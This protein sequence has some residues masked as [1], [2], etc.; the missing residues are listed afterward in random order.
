[1][2]AGGAPEMGLRIRRR[3]QKQKLVFR[4][5]SAVILLYHHEHRTWC[6]LPNELLF[7]HLF[8]ST[9][10]TSLVDRVGNF[11]AIAAKVV[12]REHVALG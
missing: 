12:A 5:V 7:A 1:M 10:S 9:A 6:L 3:N 11:L 2:Q 8:L 4:R